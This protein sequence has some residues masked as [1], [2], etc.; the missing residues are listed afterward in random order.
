MKKIFCIFTLAMAFSVASVAQEPMRTAYFLDAY[1]FRHQMNPAF[2][3][4]RSYFTIPAL[5]YMNG[6]VQSNIGMS[7][8]LYPTADGKLTTFMSSS[9]GEREFLGRLHRN[10]L[11]GANVSTSI[12]SIGAWG[13]KNGFT[14]VELNMKANTSVNLPRD[15][16]A[17]MKSPGASQHYDISNIGLRAKAYLELSLG[18]SQRINRK[19]SVGGKLKFIVGLVDARVQLDQMNIDMTESEWRVNANGTMRVSG[20][21]IVKVPTY[22]ETGGADK[23][24]RPDQI[25][26][27]EIKFA[28]ENEI[29]SSIPSMIGGYGA[30]LDLGFS[31]EVLKGLTVSASVLD[32]GFISWK[33]SIYAVTDNNP[34]SFKGFDNFSFDGDSDNSIGKQ[35]EH[36]GDDLLELI[37]LYRKDNRSYTEMLA[38]TVHAG[39]Q[40]KMPFWNGMSV[41]ALLTS[42]IQGAH[43][44]TEG[45]LS[46]NF[47]FGNAFALSG[48]YA[49]SN[50]GSTFG[51]ALN[52]H[53]RALSFYLGMDSIPTRFSKSI[54]PESPINIGIPLNDINLGLNF[55][56]VFNV[57]KRKD[58][59][60]R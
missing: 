47:A 10:N 14:T 33:N 55:G 12:F 31:F 30:A 59:D 24:Q 25:N 56:L 57:S 6:G 27:K 34:W 48:S 42:R 23:G 38:A 36:I 51:A 13:K 28:D 8:L 29:F 19:I 17:F 50:F 54:V 15:L 32:L 49:Y 11:L 2:A 16:F 45:R 58:K 9:V 60:F 18:H 41:G 20:G 3:S 44:W 40:Y 53:C 52:L 39:V 22:S 4:A 21:G 37:N 7:K 26:F 43:S 5:G 1:N 46:L 35:F